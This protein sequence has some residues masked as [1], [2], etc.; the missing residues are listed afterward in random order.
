[1]TRCTRKPLRAHSAGAFLAPLTLQ[2]AMA[3]LAGA[4]TTTPLPARAGTLFGGASFSG[5]GERSELLGV[6]SNW[7]PV[8]YLTQKL[9]V[10][11][12][13]Y[14]YGSNGTSVSV[15]GQAAEAAL[16]LQKGWDTGWVEATAGARY[17]YNRVSPEG[18]DNRNDGGE[19][20]L[21]LTVLGQQEYAQRW[22]VNGIA[23]YTFGPQAYWARGRLM[24]KVF[25][26]A[27]A[28]V[29]LIKHGDPF[30]HSTQ[31][32]LVLTG[33][34][35]TQTLNLGFFTGVKKTSGVSRA[36]YGGLEISKSF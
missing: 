4:A 11:D 14:S 3:L 24:Y 33:I 10:S 9:V 29:E 34:P 27:W 20:G 32:G 30:Y 2:L 23:S 25:G 7:L 12:Y 6:T 19:W 35:L 36:F 15:N 8:P 17:R 5:G 22:L 28:G 1:M 18:A 16:G 13:H 31:G 26:K 21:A